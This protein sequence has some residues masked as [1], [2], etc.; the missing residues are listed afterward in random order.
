MGYGTFVHRQPCGLDP[1]KRLAPRLLT[2]MACGLS[3]DVW[4]IARRVSWKEGHLC[5]SFA[6]V[7]CT[8]SCIE[9]CMDSIALI[10]P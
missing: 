2:Y 6:E 9:P 4:H 7:A 5:T 1:V 10:G 3:C 8:A